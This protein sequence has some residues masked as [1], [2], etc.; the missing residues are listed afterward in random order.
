M[1]PKAC[2][3]WGPW[4]NRKNQCSKTG[5]EVYRSDCFRTVDAASSHFFWLQIQSV[6]EEPSEVRRFQEAGFLKSEKN[7]K[8]TRQVRLVLDHPIP[9]VTSRFCN[10]LTESFQK[11]SHDSGTNQNKSALFLVRASNERAGGQ[12]Q[13]DSGRWQQRKFDEV[14]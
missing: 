14:L 7:K 10:K 5:M 4:G 11:R 1:F 6:S 8:Q 13:M 2:N 12:L 9:L 3:S